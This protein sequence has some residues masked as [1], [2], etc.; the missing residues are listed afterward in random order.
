M[1]RL[2]LAL[3]GDSEED[4][5]ALLEKLREDFSSHH[6]FSQLVKTVRYFISFSF[7]HL[8]D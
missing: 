8:P 4:I 2:T 5:A 3:D 7:S 6:E 1:Q